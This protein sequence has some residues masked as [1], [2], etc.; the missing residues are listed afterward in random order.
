MIERGDSN[1]AP[2]NFLSEVLRKTWM[3]GVK[4]LE[5]AKPTGALKHAASFDC[6][7]R[8]T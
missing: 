6:L 1:E 5:H 7:V 4:G 8:G 3:I 2:S